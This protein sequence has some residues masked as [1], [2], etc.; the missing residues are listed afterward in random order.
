[1]ATKDS[2]FS[3]NISLDITEDKE[4]IEFFKNSK[5]RVEALREVMGFY[6]DNKKG[7][8]QSQEKD[9]KD[10]IKEALDNIMVNINTSNVTINSELGCVKNNINNKSE[11]S[12][13]RDNNIIEAVN[14]CGISL[15]LE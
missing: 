2:K 3:L 1:M 9:V 4:I 11:V 8:T 6:F 14:N 7:L 12:V 15:D 10:L 5:K 13:A